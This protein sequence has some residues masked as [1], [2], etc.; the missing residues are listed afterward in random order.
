MVTISET[1]DESLFEP[2]LAMLSKI[3]IPK[4]SSTANRGNFPVGHRATTFG[5]VR[6]RFQ[7]TIGLSAPSKKW[8]HIYEEVLRIG[9]IVCPFDFKTI[10]LNNNVVCPKHFDSNN[11]G[12]SVLISFGNYEGCKIVIADKVYDARHTAIMFNGAEL[13]HWNTKDLVGNKYSLVFFS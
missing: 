2:L 9:K 12:N 10:H 4:K 6:A 3:S 1:Y 8:P 11:V 13:E 5:I 7:G